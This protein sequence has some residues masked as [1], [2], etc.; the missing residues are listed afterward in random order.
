MNMKIYRFCLSL[1]FSITLVT[2]CANEPVD[3][4]IINNGDL[5]LNDY[6]PTTLNSYWKYDVANTDNDINDLAIS[7]DSLYIDSQNANTF[8]LGVNNALPPNG[9]LSA[10]LSSGNLTRTNETL[11]L[12][13][14]FELPQEISSAIDFDIALNNYVFYDVSAPIG[15][16]LSTNGDTI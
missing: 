4:G 9:L 1:C 8:S 3:S 10:F 11:I 6:F 2:S 7:N 5:E 14:V 13:G 16:E 15:T 12:N